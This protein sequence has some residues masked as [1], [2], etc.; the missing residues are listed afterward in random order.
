MKNKILY[1]FGAS[2][3]VSGCA[4]SSFDGLWNDLRG[5]PQAYSYQSIPIEEMPAFPRYCLADDPVVPEFAQCLEGG[6]HCYQLDTGDWCM[7]PFSPFAL[8]PARHAYLQGW[9]K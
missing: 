7:G 1:L 5:T 6:T 2:L 9:S 8:E 4:G 3:V